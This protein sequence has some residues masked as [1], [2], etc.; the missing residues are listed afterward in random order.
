[1]RAGRKQ[2]L[3]KVAV[4]FGGALP[5]SHADY[6]LAAAPLR[7]IRTDIGALNQSIMRERD[8]DSFIGN[9]VFNRNLSLIRHQLG[10][11]R[12]CVFFLD[13]QQLSFDDRQ[14]PRFL[15]QNVHQVLDALDQFAVLGTDLV[16]FH[17][18][19]PVQLQFQDGIGLGVAK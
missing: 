15:R 5:R 11:P 7:P 1:M 16:N 17:P 10:Q 8:D 6:S 2:V 18:G 19:Q 13:G 9:Q 3:D 12:G 14:Y 4:L